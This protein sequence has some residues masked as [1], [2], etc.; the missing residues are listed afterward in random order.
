V[1]S[2]GWFGVGEE[3]LA[4]HHNRGA[5]LYGSDLMGFIIRDVCSLMPL[6]AFGMQL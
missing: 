4:V 2:T 5:R 6:S 3:R 1:V